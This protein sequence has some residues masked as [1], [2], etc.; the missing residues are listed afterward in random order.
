MSEQFMVIKIYKND[1]DG[2]FARNVGKSA[3][4]LSSYI[5]IVRKRNSLAELNMR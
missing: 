3:H 1:S 2:L 5:L 4:F